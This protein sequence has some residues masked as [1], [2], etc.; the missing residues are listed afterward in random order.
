V[1]PLAYGLIALIWNVLLFLAGIGV[2]RQWEKER[3]SR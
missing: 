1:N 2:G 3:R